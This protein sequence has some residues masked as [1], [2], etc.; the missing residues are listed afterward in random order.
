MSE[1]NPF[2]PPKAAVDDVRPTEAAPALWN[3]GAA[4]GWS[5]L[6][7]P[8]FG[9]YLHARNWEALG[10]PDKAATSRKWMWGSV[11]FFVVLLITSFF[12]PDSKL[13]DALGRV[14][15]LVLL[16]SWYYNL[17]KTQRAHVAARFGQDY[18]RRGWGKPLL[19]ALG[20]ILLFVVVAGFVGVIV[21]SL[22]EPG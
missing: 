1:N 17:G 8:I 6:F 19:A 7:S 13:A 9:A 12:V 22:V 16:V 4:A 21:G 3:P 10:Q 14:G 20:F 2:A 18:P 15:G 11:V 5:L